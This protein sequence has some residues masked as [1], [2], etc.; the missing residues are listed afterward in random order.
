MIVEGEY[1]RNL[2]P[3]PTPQRVNT[4]DSLVNRGLINKKCDTLDIKRLISKKY[5]SLLHI[6]LIFATRDTI[7][8][9]DLR[10]LIHVIL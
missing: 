5:K 7:D 10:G 3:H 6:G 8:P 1:I 2:I 9:L 4:C